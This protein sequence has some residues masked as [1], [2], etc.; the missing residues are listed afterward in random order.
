MQMVSEKLVSRAL[1][2]ALLIVIAFSCWQFAMST[3]MIFPD[4]YDIVDPALNHMKGIPYPILKYPTF[5]FMFYEFFFRYFSFLQGDMGPYYFSRAINLGLFL[6]ILVMF[7]FIVLPYLG[8]IWAVFAVFLFV[9]TPNMFFMG[10]I[11][12]TE[13]LIIFEMFIVMICVQKLKKNP[14]NVWLHIIAGIAC[15]LAVA[16]KMNPVLPAIYFAGLTSS[17]LHSV[18]SFYNRLKTLVKDKNVWLFFAVMAVTIPLT[19]TNIWHFQ[20][21]VEPLKIDAHF[22]PNPTACRV[23]DEFFAFPYGRYSNAFLRAFP[24]SVGVINYIAAWLALV[25]RVADRRTFYEWGLFPACYLAVALNATLIQANNMFMPCVPFIILWSVLF[26]KKIHDNNKNMVLQTFRALGIAAAILISLFQ[27]SSHAVRHHS[28][29]DIYYSTFALS[30]NNEVLYL[31]DSS[32]TTLAG[33][34]A[35]HIDEFINIE[36]PQY[37]FL[38]DSYFYNF[39]KYRNN[40]DYKRQCD[41]FKRLCSE[42]TDYEIV[43]K[44]QAEY[45]MGWLDYDPEASCTFYLLKLNKDNT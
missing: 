20:F 45:P 8:R 6:V 30:E 33:I 26:W 40:S 2:T 22:N 11:V 42:R 32:K 37:I 29:F 15:G 1:L 21:P 18:N 41:F 12:K 43:W 38:L 31:T 25:F 4:D 27:Y 10:V 17:S 9:L 36:Q 16:T 5:S 34:D 44:K 23:V 14:E 3:P 19:W 28:Y 13:G 35:K 39:C 7:Y 24:I